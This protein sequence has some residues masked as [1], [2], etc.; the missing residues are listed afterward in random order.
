MSVLTESD[1]A[2][3]ADLEAALDL[4]RVGEPSPVPQVLAQLR[5]LAQVDLVVVWCPQ[6]RILG[7]ELERLDS[8]AA[9]GIPRLRP[10]LEGFLAS[11]PYRFGWFDAVAPE[12]DQR[13]VPV[14]LRQRISDIELRASPLFSSVLAPLSLAS[15]HIERVLL[16]EDA[17][18]LGWYGV[19]TATALSDRQRALW[20]ALVPS[21]RGRLALE[22][23]LSAAVLHD[24]ALDAVLDRIGSPALV[25][26]AAGAIRGV[27]ASGRKLL[28]E[29]RDNVIAAIDA[30]RDD[31]PA[32]LTFHLSRLRD[33]GR[34]GLAC[35]ARGADA[36]GATRARRTARGLALVADAS[37]A[38]GARSRSPRLHQPRYGGRARHLRACDRTTPVRDL[39]PRGSGEP[40]RARIDRA[41]RRLSPR[42]FTR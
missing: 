4:V 26:G 1:R 17:K 35:R 32:A 28:E 6:E 21:L 38:G 15:H 41:P 14:D 3:V 25:V 5:G 29:Q 7:W 30:A 27:N 19:L 9:V 16:C 31:R 40:H 42:L 39:R 34:R 13:D 10:L 2:T 20:L 23:R 11:A 8:A 33:T 18:L 36:R 22:R 24:A 12:A 37:P